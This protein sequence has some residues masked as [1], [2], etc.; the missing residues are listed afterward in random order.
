MVG[1]S[2]VAY[3]V[4][5]IV[6]HETFRSTGFDLALFEQVLRHYSQLE[7]PSS[8]IK[9]MDSIFDDHVSPVMALL[10]P[11]Y[12]VWPSAAALLCA[13]AALIAASAIPVFLYTEPRIGRPPALMLTGAYLL[14][15][16]VQEA[17]W[18]DIHEVAFAPLLTGLAVV[19]ADR[20]HWKWSFAATLS[21]LAVKEDMSFLVVALGLWYALQGRR[22]LGALAIVAGLA[23]Y[24]LVVEVISPDYSYWSYTQLGEDLPDALGTIV[25][26]PWR[27]VEVAT[28]DWPK[29][30][31]TAYLFGAFLGLS[32]LSPLS[33]LTLPLLAERMLS[34]NPAH[35]TLE[36]HYSLTIAPVLAL[37]AA[38][39]LRRLSTGRPVLARRAPLVMLLLAIALIPAFPLVELARPS[40]YSVPPAYSAAEDGIAAV[41][42]DAAVA[43]TNRLAPHFDGRP[44]LTLLSA[45][46]PGPSWIIAATRDPSPEGVFPNQS[47]AGVRRVIAREQRKRPV[48]FER[49]GIVVLGPAR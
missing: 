11:V 19:L 45:R 7:A 47:V 3:S 27:L 49:E 32:L 12:A 13:Q 2:F 36:N 22:G 16:G 20:G 8:A 25:T 1:A 48:V 41:P 6:R 40:F 10:A 9:G 5:S 35:W 26:A 21:L 39:G 4:L 34:S 46:V 43:S 23:W 29:L 37:A 15:G 14:F 38:D 30:R 17:V 28:S 18:I 24:A 44:G 33:L 42:D 31:T